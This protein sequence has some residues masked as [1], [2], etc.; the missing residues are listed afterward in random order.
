MTVLPQFCQQPLGNSALSRI[1]W[2][3][4]SPDFSSYPA[5]RNICTADQCSLGISQQLSNT[6]QKVARGYT[7]TIGHFPSAFLYTFILSEMATALKSICQRL[8]AKTAQFISHFLEA[9][10]SQF[11]ALKLWWGRHFKNLSSSTDL[12]NNISLS[13]SQSRGTVPGREQLIQ[14]E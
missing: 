2:Q 7:I 5:N 9:T 1:G 11:F 6:L 14:P 8:L 3:P 10:R 12:F 4:L 13:Q